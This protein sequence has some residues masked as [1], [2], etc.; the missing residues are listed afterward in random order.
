M[1]LSVLADLCGR[2]ILASELRDVY[3]LAATASGY[4][5]K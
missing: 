5:V 1:L 4:H 2:P 3:S